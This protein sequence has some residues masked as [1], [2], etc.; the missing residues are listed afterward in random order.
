DI[1]QRAHRHRRPDEGGEGIAHGRMPSRAG[2]SWPAGHRSRRGRGRRQVLKPC[3]ERLERRYATATRCARLR[4]ALQLVNR[5]ETLTWEGRAQGRIRPAGAVAEQRHGL[6]GTPNIAQ[7]PSRTSADVCELAPDTLLVMT[8]AEPRHATT[9]DELETL[10]RS[11]RSS[12][13]V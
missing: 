11:R 1:Q 6:L 10:V 5:F 4:V 2:T 9:L 13:R 7:L 12:L 8:A 3:D